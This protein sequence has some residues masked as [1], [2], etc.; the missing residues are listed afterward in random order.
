MCHWV[1]CTNFQ[2]TILRGALRISVYVYVDM[3]LCLVRKKKWIGEK[4]GGG[5]GV[6]VKKRE[7]LVSL[8]MLGKV[9]AAWGP[10]G[11]ANCTIQK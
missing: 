11:I 10:R 6:N 2:S 9:A 7:L 3:Y 4:W 5:K 1:I 8:F